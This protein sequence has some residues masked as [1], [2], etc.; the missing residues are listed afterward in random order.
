MPADEDFDVVR[1]A[2]A[3][4]GRTR[5]HAREFHPEI[6]AVPFGAAMEGKA[7]RGPGQLL[8]WWRDEIMVNWEFFQ[9]LPRPSSASATG[10]S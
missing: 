7:Y 3:A 4:A 5:R 2:W 1:R 10:S 8:G 9:V 6:V